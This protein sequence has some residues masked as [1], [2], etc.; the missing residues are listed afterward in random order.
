MDDTNIL[1]ESDRLTTSRDTQGADSLY[2]LIFD[3]AARLT[4][5][6]YIDYLTCICR[7]LFT[8]N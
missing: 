5:V 3:V 7:A 1:Y 2:R 4:A 6:D 8:H